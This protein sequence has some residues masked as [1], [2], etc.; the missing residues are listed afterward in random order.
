MEDTN[1]KL[2]NNLLLTNRKK[3]Q[4][5]N[6]YIHIDVKNVCSFTVTVMQSD[7]K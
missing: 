1:F 6:E 2:V 4:R 3:Y 5:L 7:I